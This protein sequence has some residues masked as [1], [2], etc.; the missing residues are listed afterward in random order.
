[1][2]FFFAVMVS[3]ESFAEVLPLEQNWQV[4]TSKD[5]GKEGDSLSHRVAP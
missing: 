4:Q 1:M 2:F 5:L 3:A